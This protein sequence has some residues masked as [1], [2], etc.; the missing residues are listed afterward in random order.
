MV[1]NWSLSKTVCVDWWLEPKTGRFVMFHSG[2][3]NIHKVLPVT[4][5]NR[6]LFSMWFSS[7]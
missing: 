4:S 7:L 5:G 6:F 3:G 2:M 1:E